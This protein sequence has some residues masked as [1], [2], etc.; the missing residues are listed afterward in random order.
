M[1]PA[2]VVLYFLFCLFYIAS[3]PVQY[4]RLCFFSCRTSNRKSLIGSGQSSGLPRPHS[5]LSSLAGEFMLSVFESHFCSFRTIPTGRSELVMHNVLFH[6]KC[7]QK[8]KTIAIKQHGKM[9]S[10]PFV[11]TL[12]S[13]YK[14]YSAPWIFPA[15]KVKGLFLLK[16][17]MSG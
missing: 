6:I 13:K 15:E 2:D 9:L 14:L 3:F 12:A 7:I 17:N 16:T 10:V 4:V 11:T 5:P 8:N 1:E